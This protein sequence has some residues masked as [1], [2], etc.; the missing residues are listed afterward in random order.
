MWA[1]V[2]DPREQVLGFRVV[3]GVERDCISVAASLLG[4][5]APPVVLSLEAKGGDHRSLKVAARP[6]I[7]TLLRSCEPGDLRRR[8]DVE[9][10]E[11]V[12]VDP[13]PRGKSREAAHDRR[14]AI[15]K[16][17]RDVVAVPAAAPDGR[18]HQTAG[19]S[20]A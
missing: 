15:E 6:P 12:T 16:M 14:A 2:E 7:A 3:V 19:S 5:D 4:L 18:E 11:R 9:T 13:A 10:L 17:C 1:G 8:L 20:G